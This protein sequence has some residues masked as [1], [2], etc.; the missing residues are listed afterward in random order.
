LRKDAPIDVQLPITPMLDM[1]FQLLAFFI[2][3]F[4]A[5]NAYEGQLDLHLPRTG[6][7]AAKS[8]DQVNLNENS[9]LDLDAGG[10]VAVVVTAN[11]DGTV[12][13]LTVREKANATPVADAKA[14]RAALAK[15][16]GELGGGRGNIKIESDARLK[17]AKLVEVMDACLAAGF[18]QVTFA[19]PGEGKR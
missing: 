7:A 17:Y 9:D 12:E 5:A 14:L 1:S 13:S 6:V 8:A 16:H 4:K 2:M 11:A 10:D 19:P 3:T 18:K 15:V